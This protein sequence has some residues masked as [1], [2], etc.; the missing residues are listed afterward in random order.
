MTKNP[1]L[2]QLRRLRTALSPKWGGSWDEVTHLCQTWS[3]V[4][5][6]PEGFTAEVCIAE[7]LADTNLA[8]NPANR[9]EID[10]L[11][12]RTEPPLLDGLRRTAWEG[13]RS[14][15]QDWVAAHIRGFDIHD[16]YAAYNAH[17]FANNM[18]EPVLLERLAE[19]E[20]AKRARIRNDPFNP[21]LV[22]LRIAKLKANSDA[23]LSTETRS[24][25]RDQLLDM[26]HYARYRPNAWMQMARYLLDLHTPD[27]LRSTGGAIGIQPQ[28]I[29]FW[30]KAVV[31]GNYDIDTLAAFYV[32]LAQPL[33]ATY[34]SEM[35]T[36]PVLAIAPERAEASLT[37][38]QRV[39]LAKYAAQREFLLCP[40]VKTR[41]LLQR[42]C[43]TARGAQRQTCETAF[44][45]FSMEGFYPHERLNE[46]PTCDGFVAWRSLNPTFQQDLDAPL[47]LPVSI[48]SDDG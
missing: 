11:L 48:S 27:D 23:P 43:D 47:T 42:A 32:E 2:G 6:G 15:Q 41:F 12:D 40:F 19:I 25:A 16:R 30:E 5:P 3:D 4:V 31:A 22:D 9:P 1:D 36:A 20:A 18:N 29:P 13:D 14:R 10:A 34:Q 39:Q 45:P 24:Q 38:E 37:P 21:D 28:E 33:T 46:A 44:L 8:R 17:Y 7:S 35:G 26:L